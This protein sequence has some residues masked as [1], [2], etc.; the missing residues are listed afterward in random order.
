[1]HFLIV[2]KRE[3]EEKLGTIHLH[4]NKYRRCNEESGY[5]IQIKLC[6]KRKIQ[7]KNRGKYEKKN[8]ISLQSNLTRENC[9]F[10]QLYL[11]TIDINMEK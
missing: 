10:N 5:F 2:I 8:F 11:Y 4:K 1:M 9:I 6:T 7:E 3:R